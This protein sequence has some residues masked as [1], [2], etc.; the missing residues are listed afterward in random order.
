MAMEAEVFPS[1]LLSG[2]YVPPP[3]H[4]QMLPRGPGPQ[5]PRCAEPMA[6]PPPPPPR[7]TVSVTEEIEEAPMFSEE[8]EEK[9]PSDLEE[10]SIFDD[11]ISPSV[12]AM[13]YEMHRREMPPPP[14][15][16]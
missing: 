10:A 11:E 1:E 14:M 12:A 16:S 13:R 9:P 8:D 3:P 15:Y 6:P 2:N 5:A 7:V 4:L